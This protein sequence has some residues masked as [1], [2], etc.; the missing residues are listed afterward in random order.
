MAL[1]ELR[2]IRRNMASSDATNTPDGDDCMEIKQVTEVLIPAGL[3]PPAL[4]VL[5]P[6]EDNYTALLMQP[7]GEIEASHTGV[8]NR[9]RDL[10]RRQF[11]RFLLD[12]CESQADLVI[13]PEYSMPWETL[14]EAVKK[15]TIP[16]QGKLWALGCESTTLE[17]LETF[18]EELAPFGTVLFEPLQKHPTR[19]IN[20]LVY[21]F[22]TSSTNGDGTRQTVLLVQFKTYPMGDEEHFEVNGMQRGTW[23]YQFG[24]TDQRLRLVSLIC[25]DVFA[26]DDSHA[27]SIYKES[28]TLHI[29]LNPKPR[30]E[31]FR[32]YRD[33][34]LGFQGDTTELICLN[35][36][37]NVQQCCDEQIT[38]WKN[39]AGSAWYLKPTKFDDRDLTLLA[40]HRRGLYY[41]WLKPLRTHTLFFNYAPATFL[42]KATKVAHTAVRASLSRRRGPQLTR[43][44]VWNEEASA[45]VEQ[46]GAEDGFSAIVGE[47]GN[48]E[49]EL[50]RI[51]ARNPLEVER[52]LALCA[53]KVEQGMEWY[54]VCHLD[55][56]VIDMSEVIC[57]LTFCQ[58]TSRSANA[59]R[60]ARLKRCGRLWN[61]LD[62]GN[63]LPPALAD[64]KQGFHL[65]W[66]E[67]SPHQNAISASGE[68]ATV[69]YMGEEANEAQVEAIAKMVAEYLHRTSPDADQSLAAKQRLAVWFRDDNGEIALHD[70]HRYVRIDQPRNTSE[71]DIGREL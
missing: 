48:A 55:S 10:A 58:D 26:F 46:N 66:S 4:N 69:I 59:F 28:L 17:H 33:R 44:C 31:Q 21:V 9:N 36:A 40:N 24:G 64:F 27:A 50:K 65:E 49:E 57:R 32:S 22:N 20:P 14:V 52:V 15:S 67:K 16:N 30:H 56:C 13:T 23:I 62:S 41:T 61:I 60:I 8:R 68:R 35:W 43:T 53:G 18:R 37:S 2:I 54:K 12:A 3:N 6:N 51:A 71:F 5:I 42:L 38:P 34:L 1:V 63:S 25:S 47:S 29:Q 70:H 7:H 19:F 11:E 45:W 39:I